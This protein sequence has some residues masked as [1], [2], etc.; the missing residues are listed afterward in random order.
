[1]HATAPAWEQRVAGELVAE[2]GAATVGRLLPRGTGPALDPTLHSLP[3]S[4]AL[5]EW[6][7]QPRRSI[8]VTDRERDER[9]QRRRR[10]PSRPEMRPRLG[11]GTGR[12]GGD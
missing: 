6:T 10:A 4:V 9:G 7:R 11:E 12:I 5:V 1:M 2:E 8:A 3:P